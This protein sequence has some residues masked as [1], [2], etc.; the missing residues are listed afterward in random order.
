MPGT[1]SQE[2]QRRQEEQTKRRAEESVS[3]FGSLEEEEEDEPI[4]L[5]FDNKEYQGSKTPSQSDRVD[6]PETL[7]FRYIVQPPG[8]CP[9]SS[10]LVPSAR[11]LGSRRRVVGAGLGKGKEISSA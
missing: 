4:S 6:E 2:K 11:R 7:P 9:R 3:E 10:Q 5:D 8:Q 1:V